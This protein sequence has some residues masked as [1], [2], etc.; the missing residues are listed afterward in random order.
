MSYYKKVNHI[1]DRDLE[2]LVEKRK[3][4]VRSSKENNFDFDSIL[5]GLYNDPSHFI[6]EILQN[7]EDEGAKKVRFDLFEDRLDT[8]HNG[9]DFD[10]KD[11][12]GVTGI[13]ISKKKNDLT[14]IGKFGV[15]FKSV[16]AVTE[17]PYISSGKYK[18]KIEN[19]VIPSVV[20]NNEQV[21]GTLI[22]LPFNHKLRSREEVFNLVSEKLAN[23]GLKTLLFLKNIESIQWQTRSSSGNYSRSSKYFQKIKNTKRVVIKSPGIIEEYIVIEKPINIGGKKLKVE[24][25][26]KLN[27]G[28]RGKKIV[29]SEP[30]SK[31]VVFFP[32]DKPTYLNFVIQGPYKTTPNRENIPLDD[33]QNKKIIEE[34]VNL[35]AKSLP[36]IKKLDL[37]DVDFL[38][39]L[40]LKLEAKENEPIYSAIYQRVRDKLRSEELL[41][42]LNHKYT[43]ADNS[44]L[45][46]GKE[47]TEFLDNKDL[48]RLFSKYDW[49]DTNITYDKTKELREYLIN[50]LKVEEV[51]FEIFAGKITAEF[52]Q[53]KSDKWMV[54]FYKR[55][56]PQES[57]W[58][59]RDYSPGILRAK[60]IIRLETGEH[61]APFNDR[62]ERQVYL[63]T[64]I[65][66]RYKTIKRIF[67]KDKNSLKFLKELGITEPSLAAEIKEYI[68]PKY[69]ADNHSKDDEYIEDFAKLLKD[70]ETIPSD[71][72]G[73]FVEKL[74]GAYFVDSVNNKTG[75]SYPRKPSEVYFHTK[76]LEEYFD[77]Y[78]SVSFVSDELY[79][80]FGQ[81]KLEPFL[82]ELGVEDK[83]RRI[84]IQGNLSD[85]KKRGFQNGEFSIYYGV[86]G[87][88][89]ID[90][91]YK[92][93][94]NFI[95]KMTTGKS[96][97]LWKLFLKNIKNL[98]N[99]EAEN[100]FKG[101]VSLVFSYTT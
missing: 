47:L 19:F 57:L 17:T 84:K 38:K 78:D 66:S 20:N 44:L 28:K 82:K 83:P 59:D 40:P 60:P 12:D 51:D 64:K 63:P 37:L 34:T 53:T 21:N 45:A 15:G 22:K 86:R 46:R 27:K 42:A 32:T 67:T 30:N 10:F 29:V 87:E 3:N 68:L 77:D 23:I 89:I 97:L 8:Y 25:A 100:F 76:D 5:A 69:K 101:G 13:G 16:F 41:P 90:Y 26:Y 7:A 52:L 4:W 39:I 79:K 9:K 2:K 58:S 70:Y 33:E 35:I 55:L 72:K 80:K 61:I 93:L 92:G 75:E 91:E 56:L 96:F 11:I 24:V 43:K 98:S 48:Q 18:I 74:S 1:E 71:E 65:K 54:D 94:E 81:E 95:N 85:E 49:L 88:Q 6:Y 14:A 36:I 31:L 50:E 99:Y 62:G 73:E